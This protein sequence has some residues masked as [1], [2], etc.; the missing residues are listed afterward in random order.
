MDEE[1]FAK[2][3]KVLEPYLQQGEFNEEEVN[4]KIGELTKLLKKRRMVN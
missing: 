4:E 3:K 2:I 1:L